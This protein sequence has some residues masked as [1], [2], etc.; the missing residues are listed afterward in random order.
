MPGCHA[1]KGSQIRANT[2]KNFFGDQLIYHLSQIGIFGK[3]R[4]GGENRQAV[5]AKSFG[6]VGFEDLKSLI[7]DSV[8]FAF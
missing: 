1:G 7:L 8:A 3:F 4:Y 5:K 6:G 2:R